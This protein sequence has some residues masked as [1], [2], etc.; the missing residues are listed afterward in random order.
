MGT[1]SND[2]YAVGVIVYD[3]QNTQRGFIL[4]YDGFSWKEVYRANTY[5]S[6]QRLRN[7]GNHI[8]IQGVKLSYTA[9]DTTEFYLLNGNNLI[10]I[11]YD[12]IFIGKLSLIGIK[13]Y[14]TIGKDI[15]R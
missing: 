1:N 3:S 8:Y 5:S 13:V 9:R 10:T 15:Y 2:V 6:F 12:E 4:H 11:Y 7:E 14:F